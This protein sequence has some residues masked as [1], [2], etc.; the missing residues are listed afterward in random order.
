MVK[1]RPFFTFYGG[2]YRV[3]PHY[4][5]PIYDT[6]I[7]PFA[8]SAGYSLRYFNHKIILVDRDPVIAATWKYL[9]SVSPQEILDL[10]DVLPNQSINDIHVIQEARWLIG[11]WLNKGTTSPC[12]TPSAWMR[13]GIRP[14]S[15]WGK[16][17]RERIASQVPYI[18]HWKIFQ[19][20]YEQCPSTEASWFVDPPYSLVERQYKC[21]RKY[22]DY[23]ALSLWCQQRKGQVIVCESV[24]ANWLPFQP[25]RNIK[26]NEGRTG[27]KISQ[28][29]IWTNAKNFV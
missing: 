16:A 15:Q 25:F 18:R 9:I 13:S 24:G 23:K 10:P 14:N 8:G 1:L 2:K 29:A 26:A 4:P 21:G 22:I 3:A 11:W 19:G 27:G 20:S 5:K 17:I 12:R 6:I 28:E 7:E